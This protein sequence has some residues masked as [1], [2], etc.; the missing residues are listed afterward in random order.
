VPGLNFAP[1]VTACPPKFG[2][3][4]A[5]DL[6][7]FVDH[8][9]LAHPNESY[10]PLKKKRCK[11]FSNLGFILVVIEMSAKPITSLNYVHGPIE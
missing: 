8:R 7:L 9:P 10:G 11:K 5:A 6:A 1:P 2:G 4:G 3:W